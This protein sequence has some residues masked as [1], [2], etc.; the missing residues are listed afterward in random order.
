MNLDKQFKKIQNEDIENI[1]SQSF[2][3]NLHRKRVENDA[4]SAR[5][6]SG[7]AS[8]CILVV[9]GFLTLNQ[10][11]YDPGSFASTDLIPYEEMDA[12]TESYIV[13]LADYLIDTSNDIWETLD[14][15]DKINF[16]NVI[17]SNYGDIN[18]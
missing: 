6:I 15:F 9:F 13:D 12:E 10:L 18:E 4:R 7:I 5:F 1:D 8:F 3:V 2:I 11:A 17:A 16:D 14:F